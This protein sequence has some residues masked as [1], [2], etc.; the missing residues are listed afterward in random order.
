MA[1]S[2]TRIPGLSRTEVARI[3]GW[4]KELAR[5]DTK[6]ALPMTKKDTSVLA[7]ALKELLRTRY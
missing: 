4:A 7:K 1:A 6:V 3:Q 5:Y 2:K